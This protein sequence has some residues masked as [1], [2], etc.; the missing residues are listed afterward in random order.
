[1]S[2]PDI[3]GDLTVQAIDHEGSAAIRA[4]SMRGDQNRGGGEH[5]EIYRFKD[6]KDGLRVANALRD[7]SLEKIKAAEA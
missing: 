7:I 6:P 4:V 3:R 5:V 1:M 2:K